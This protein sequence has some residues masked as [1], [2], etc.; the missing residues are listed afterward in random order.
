[1]SSKCFG[2]SV[3]CWQQQKS[4]ILC[5]KVKNPCKES[6]LKG[7]KRKIKNLL[8]GNDQIG[9]GLVWIKVQYLGFVK[10]ETLLYLAL[11]VVAYGTYGL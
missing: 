3:E 5:K 7:Q 8:V 6:G 4:V 1:M 2:T 10:K 9:I 11:P